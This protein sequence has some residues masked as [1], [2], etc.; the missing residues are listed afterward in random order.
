[1]TRLDSASHNSNASSQAFNIVGYGVLVLGIITIIWS[2]NHHPQAKPSASTNGATTSKLS[3]PDPKKPTVNNYYQCWSNSTHTPDTDP[4]TCKAD[5]K[6]YQRPTS[7]SNDSVRNLSKATGKA[8]APV[9]S[10]AKKNF[11]D[12]AKSNPK[13]VATSAVLGFADKHVYF[14]TTCVNDHNSFLIDN[15][16]SWQQ[17]NIPENIITC[18]L[19]NKYSIPR[20]AVTNFEFTSRVPTCVDANGQQKAIKA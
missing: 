14:Q 20:Q 12:C 1:M 10:L 2:I 8:Q 4:S 5:G 16:N 3:T 18:D 17:V 15:N 9:V 19:I 11:E 6:T 13:A 7:F